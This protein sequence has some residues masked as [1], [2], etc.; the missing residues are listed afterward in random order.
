MV[1]R[2]PHMT[3]TCD[4][5]HAL[6]KH[7]T[8]FKNNFFSTL[9]LSEF[10][11]YLS[12]LFYGTPYL[13]YCYLVLMANTLQVS[14]LTEQN[15]YVTAFCITI[16]SVISRKWSL[17]DCQASCVAF[18]AEGFDWVHVPVLS[19]VDSDWKVQ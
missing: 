13:G 6:Q 10:M 15:V 16:A 5:A 1:K 11:S 3:F 7:L 14:F 19:E 2:I 17:F 4:L 8:T 12:L 9:F 18:N